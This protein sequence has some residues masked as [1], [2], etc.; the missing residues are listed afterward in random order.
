MFFWI[1]VIIIGILISGFVVYMLAQVQPN[2]KIE[3]FIPDELRYQI[4]TCQF[5]LSFAEML[6]LPRTKIKETP[7]G[8]CVYS[9]TLPDLID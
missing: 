8:V 5:H 2:E 6:D 1:V 4:E 9:A 7:G 3:S